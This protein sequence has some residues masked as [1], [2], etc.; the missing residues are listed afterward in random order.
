MTSRKHVV[1]AL[2]L[3]IGGSAACAPTVEKP[4]IESTLQ[5]FLEESVAAA[6]F[7]R[8]VALHVDAP[9]LGLFWEG[10]VGFA[11]PANGEAMTPQHPVRIASNTKTYIA[12]AVLRL[13]EEGRIDLD[14]AITKYLPAEFVT[15]L[16]GDGY[17]P[18]AI[19]VRHLLTHTSGL[20]DHGASEQYGIDIVANPKHRWSRTEQLQICVDVGDPV[21]QPG[22]VYNYSDTGYILLGRML[23]D[24]TGHNLAGAVWSLID[25][26]R[27]GLDSTWFETIEPRPAAA[28]DRAHQFFGDV[29]V[30]AFDPSFDLWGGGGIA[31]TVG[32]LA[33]F[34]RLLFA[35]DVYDDP[36]S[37][38]TMLTTFDGVRA[39]PGASERALPP[40]AYRMGVWVLSGDGYTIYRHSGFW[41][42]SA[43]WVP[44]LDLV[45]TLTVNQ[46][47]AGELF[48]TLQDGVLEI[49]KGHAPSS[50]RQ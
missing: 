48:T 21:G 24:A 25:R 12:A 36:K 19:T 40:G 15:T 8:G 22:T 44:E 30:T 29:D 46:H 3:A 17:Q 23:E 28:L 37:L 16:E 45:V 6:G 27:L 2:A 14:E 41:C 39:A 20:F 4:L 11:D 10:A 7:E 50:A 47:E 31:T 5:V 42:T 32:D 49:V 35:G 38:D 43:T 13:W 1:L 34:T 18:Q 26:Q 9:P 33:R